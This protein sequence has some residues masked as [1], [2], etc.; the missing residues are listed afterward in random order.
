M[1]END[2]RHDWVG[3]SEALTALRGDLEAAWGDG[4]P[5]NGQPVGVRFKI[6]PIELTIQIG[7]TRATKGSAGV[8]WHIL[9]LGGDH[10]REATSTQIL[11]MRLTPILVD[12]QG[13]PLPDHRQHMGDSGR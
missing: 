11:K 4:K 6:D 8:K 9:A 1:A 7:A 10:S 3:L 2:A 5:A 13:A 12:E